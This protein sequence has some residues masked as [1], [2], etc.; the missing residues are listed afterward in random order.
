MHAA[1][2]IWGTWSR[3]SRRAE[4]ALPPT[5]C[6]GC[7]ECGAATRGTRARQAETLNCYACGQAIWVAPATVWPRPA[8]VA[9]DQPIARGPAAPGR[10]PRG[11]PAPVPGPVP[12]PI[13]GGE[14]GHGRAF[15]SPLGWI[16]AWAAAVRRRVA[17][18]V[19]R[20]VGWFT[21]PRVAALAA[22]V[23]IA[24]TLWWTWR[25]SRRARFIR[26]LE[27]ATVAGKQALLAGDLVTAQQQLT[28][29]ARAAQGLGLGTLAER[30]G[31]QWAAEAEL[32][33]RLTGPALEE[34]FWDP[35]QAQVGDPTASAA[36]FRERYAGRTLIL[37][38]LLLPP[39]PA[40]GAKAAVRI[41][42]SFS[43]GTGRVEIDLTQQPDLARLAA[44]TPRRVVCGLELSDLARTEG[45]PPRWIIQ[46]RPGSLVWL[47][48]AGPLRLRGWP[49]DPEL[50]SLL[51]RQSQQLGLEI[52][53]GGP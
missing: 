20:V 27:S 52:E 34:F 51:D 13:L 35:A 45:Q 17:E 53:E 24:T 50:E 4:P 15:P 25:S 14:Q 18:A 49:E 26:E 7:P 16:R 10:A 48:L 36:R 6:F 46:P 47:T 12:E 3:P 30:R 28:M 23:L 37:D 43:A 44:A 38:A 19:G 33:G 42:W 8:P 32:W 2:G 41:D 11:G 31:L 22:L 9:S 40:D 39:E 29:A 1:R 21:W 5:Y